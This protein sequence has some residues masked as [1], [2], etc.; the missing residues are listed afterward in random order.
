MS[1]LQE[2][3]QKQINKLGKKF[4]D[5]IWS[6]ED[7]N[8]LEEF[9][10]SYDQL[11]INNSSLISL[12]LNKNLQNFIL[13][14]R[15]KRTKSIIR[16]LQRKNN[17]GMDLTRMSDIAG[18]RVIVNNLSNQNKAIEIIKSVLNIDKIYDYRKSEQNY[19]SVHLITK[20]E[21]KYLEIQVRTIAQ[22]T[23]ADESEDF[24]EH[25]KQGF[26]TDEVGNYL[27]ILSDITNKIDSENNFEDNQI[28]NF[29][30]EKRSP[31]KGK[32]SI[33]K[34]I[35]DTYNVNSIEDPKY[36]LIVYDSLDS[37]LIS[38]DEFDLNEKNYVFDLYKY[39]AKLL[40]DN[41][42]EIIFFISSLGSKVLR[43]SHP[44]FFMR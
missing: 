3:S 31:I 6:D 27:K 16:K 38:E 37:T 22:Q 30:F 35:F 13:V 39:K 24:G 32:L 28:N 1:Q 18:L 4:R 23:W 15:L 8:F 42:Y 11:L 14:G 5:S 19:R 29:L 33:I 41:R 40:D 7:F 20:I 26:Y 9:K 17:Y 25:A 21:D 44:R 43:V 10:K 36:F 34:K 12:K 2:I